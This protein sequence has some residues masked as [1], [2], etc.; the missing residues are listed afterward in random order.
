MCHFI[1]KNVNH[2]RDPYVIRSLGT[3]FHLWWDDLDGGGDMAGY[4][5]L[6]DGA[7]EK[8]DLLLLLA[9]GRG[10]IEGWFQHYW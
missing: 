1:S 9:T 10:D 8:L 4:V 7:I 2:V 6:F 3:L 5:T